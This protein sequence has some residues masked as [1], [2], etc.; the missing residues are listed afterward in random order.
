[1]SN[2]V[3]ISSRA[4]LVSLRLNSWSARKYDKKVTKEVIEQHGTGEE[5]GRFN[6]SLLPAERPSYKELTSFI[7][8]V[9]TRHYELTLPWGEE[10]TRLLPIANH[11]KYQELQKEADR[12]IPRLKRAFLSEYPTLKENARKFLNTMYNEE[13]YPSVA[14]IGNKFQISFVITSVPAGDFRVGLSNEVLAVLRSQEHSRVQAATKVAMDDTWQRLYDVVRHMSERL[15]PGAII[16]DVLIDNLQEQCD[17]L[18]RLN[19]TGDSRFEKLR[20]DTLK[21]LAAYSVEAIKA[22]KHTRALMAQSADQI[23]TSIRGAR[24]IKVAVPKAA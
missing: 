10:W 8:S 15:A 1:M 5:A 2:N 22:D 4:L 6:K 16:R 3:D 19:I 7:A 12:E 21:K 24:R 14:D 9:R 17:L 23:L 20:Q 13:D 18:A 11:E